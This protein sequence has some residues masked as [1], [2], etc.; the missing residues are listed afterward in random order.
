MLNFRQAILE[1][2]E[3]FFE[4]ANDSFVRDNSYSS[5]IIEYKDHVKWFQAKLNDESC[6]IFVFEN[7]NNLKVGQ[8]RIQKESDQQ[9]VIGISID[10]KHR[11]KG[12]AKEMLEIATDWFFNTN[13][14]FIINAFIKEKNLNSKY[15]FEKAGF[16][17]QKMLEYENFNSF[18]YI[19][20]K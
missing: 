19:K 16:I 17:F 11:G 2:L 7:D 18:H 3:L 8:I 10:A 5:K 4:W 15:A 12:Y 20:K 9:A 14:D 1:D 13:P 6:L